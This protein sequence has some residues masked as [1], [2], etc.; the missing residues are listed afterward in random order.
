MGTPTD[1]IK[2]LS[3]FR[4]VKRKKEL[5]KRRGKNTRQE[6]SHINRDEGKIVMTKWEEEWNNI[7]FHEC[8]WNSMENV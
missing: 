5:E 6:M 2:S 8:E 1:N 3:S 4:L 7:Q